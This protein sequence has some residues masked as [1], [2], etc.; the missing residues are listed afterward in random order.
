MDLCSRIRN[1]RKLKRL[2]LRDMAK[3]CGVSSSMLSQVENGKVDP[4]LSTLRKI[5]IALEVPLFYLVM[6]EADGGG[7][8]IHKENRR[9]ISFHKSGLEYEIIHSDPGKKIAVMIGTLQP[10][11][12]TSKDP[13]PHEGEECLIVLDG[14]LRVEISLEAV[15][16]DKE[17]SFYF[18]SSIPHRLTNTGSEAC[19]FY[20]IITPPKF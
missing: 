13:L 11:G 4:S 7:R 15:D 1:L 20:L 14:R 3:D 12:A 8:L 10:G 16:L 9:R 5:A 6:E 19:R 17:D 18:D 2:S